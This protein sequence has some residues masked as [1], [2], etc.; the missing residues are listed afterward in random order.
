MTLPSDIVA[1]GDS[2]AQPSCVAFVVAEQLLTHHPAPT[3]A[4]RHD[5][6]RAASLAVVGAVTVGREDPARRLG[7][8][9]LALK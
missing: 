8:W 5:R 2:C 7:S 4:T 9:H 6:A 3:A 1:G